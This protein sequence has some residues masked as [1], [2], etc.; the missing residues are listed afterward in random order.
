MKTTARHVYESANNRRMP[1]MYA[2]P[3]ER[4][5]FGNDPPSRSGTISKLSSF[6]AILLL[7]PLMLASG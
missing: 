4:Q 6:S 2:T 3:T 7:F 5:M 1:T